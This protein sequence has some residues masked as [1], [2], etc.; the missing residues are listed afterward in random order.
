MTVLLFI[1]NDI[2]GIE[3]SFFAPGVKH[4]MIFKELHPSNKL[5]LIPFIF[6]LASYLINVIDQLSK[7]FVI[8]NKTISYFHVGLRSE[9]KFIVLNMAGD[10]TTPHV[11]AARTQSPE[12]VWIKGA[13]R[14]GI[15]SARNLIIAAANTNVPTT[16]SEISRPLIKAAF[17]EWLRTINVPN[18]NIIKLKPPMKRR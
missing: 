9:F 16:L 1:L 6:R 10:N 11:R 2:N 14:E 15:V 13:Y 7:R 12:E 5:F 8:T 4:Q 17:R 18:E 3:K